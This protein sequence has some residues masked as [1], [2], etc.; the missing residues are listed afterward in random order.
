MANQDLQL[1]NLKILGQHLRPGNM[2]C[3]SDQKILSFLSDEEG[4]E[5]RKPFNKILFVDQ[6]D[7]FKTYLMKC[8]QIVPQGQELSEAIES[9]QKSF[10]CIGLQEKEVLPKLS[11]F[12]IANL[13]TALFLI[14]QCDGE[15]V[16]RS[17]QCRLLVETDKSCCDSCSNLFENLCIESN[18]D[19]ME[20]NEHYLVDGLRVEDM[21]ETSISLKE[22]VL[23]VKKEKDPDFQVENNSKLKCLNR[24]TDTK[25]KKYTCSFCDESFFYRNSLS[26]HLSKVHCKNLR[27]E[28]IKERIFNCVQCDKKYASESILAKHMKKAHLN[29]IKSEKKSVYIKCHFCQDEYKVNEGETM[30]CFYKVHLEKKH[31]DQD[32]SKFKDDF[33]KIDNLSLICPIC[34]G[35][36]GSKDKVDA[37]IKKMHI[38]SQEMVSC[39]ICG[40][41]L[42]KFSL[43]SHITNAH[44]EPKFVCTVCGS[45]FK[46]ESY[47]RYHMRTHNPG[48]TEKHHQ[49][50][51][52]G[53]KFVNGHTLKKHIAWT[54]QKDFKFECQHC[55][56]LFRS[57]QHLSVH[58]RSVHTKEKPFPCEVCGFTCARLDNLNLHR[59][60]VH[61]L[62]KISRSQIEQ[63]FGLK[64]LPKDSI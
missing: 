14:D 40:K 23:N 5:L 6:D 34:G 19:Q 3:N 63:L 36:Y 20:E 27:G 52:C 39:H 25:V 47:L 38:N 43:P 55:A 32:L 22:E 60:K 56:K 10:F 13:T 37:H 12:G 9:L 64:Q 50:E 35:I 24:T 62:E 53:K 58:I 1:S 41:S 49:C 21:L 26:K 18:N 57:P 4:I 2:F 54:H 45:K 8:I 15:F 59:K 31:S 7:V 33:E 51:E 61:K 28:D 30:T 44:S 11:S 46:Q 16:Y 29:E 42:K 17:R 48:G